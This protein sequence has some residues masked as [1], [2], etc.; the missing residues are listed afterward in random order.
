M[1]DQVVHD[2]QGLVRQFAPANLECALV[3]VNV[4][5]PF[6]AGVPSHHV[7]VAPVDLAV[8]VL[9]VEAGDLAVPVLVVER[10]DHPVDQVE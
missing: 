9:V 1:A 2:Q 7:M 3:L 6:P 5:A 4:P 10:V 8:P